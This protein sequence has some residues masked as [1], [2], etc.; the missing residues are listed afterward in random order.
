MTAVDLVRLG[1]V[2]YGDAFAWQRERASAVRAGG[3][4][5]AL[6]LLQ[7]PPVYTLGARGRRDGLLLAPAAFEARGAALVE[8]DRGGD[9]TFHGPGQLVAYPILNVRARGL[10]A[11]DYVRALEAVAS[12]TLE[13]VGVRGERVGGRPGVWVDGAKVCAVGVRIREGVST[14]GIALNVD[15]DLEWFD[16]IVPCGLADARVTS[17]A[18]LLGA[19]APSMC[20]VEE[21]FA[22]AFEAV[23]DLELLEAG[24]P[25][26]P[27]CAGVE[28]PSAVGAPA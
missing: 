5:E 17:L 10:G 1:T 20:A 11:A 13:A 23:F 24:P 21:A 2:E 4:R 27:G 28:A 22:E 6:A 8:S 15:V 12:A 26:A 3:A 18:Q 19:R 14:H 9:V 16:A 25:A 7:H